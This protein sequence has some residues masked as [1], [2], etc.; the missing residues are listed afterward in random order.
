[1]SSWQP[2]TL[3]MIPG[4]D[5]ALDAVGQGAGMLSGLLDTL[6]GILKTIAQI[7]QFMA[8]VVQASI[9]ALK[10]LIQAAIYAIYDLLNSG[11]YFYLD[12][13]AP[14]Y[15]AQPDG[16]GGFLTRWEESFQ[17]EGDGSRPVYD[18]AQPVSAMLFLVGA[19]SLPDF[20]NL[21][22][23]LGTLFGAPFWMPTNPVDSPFMIP[24]AIEKSMGT[25]PDWKGTTLGEAVPPFARLGEILTKALSMIDISD[26]V[27]GVLEELARVIE[28]KASV[29]EALADEIDAIV[30]MIEAL[31]QSGLY[32]LQVDGEGITELVAKAKETPKPPLE[33]DSYV[34][35][36]CLLGATADFGPVT[37]LLGA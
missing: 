2:F 27:S 11:L 5:S 23:L 25:P 20:K 30:A 16:V 34:A 28:L 29:L 24:E 1:M 21:L 3:A 37:E 33:Q 35:G 9:A 12:Q 26:S 36:V 18:R 10:A 14:F 22:D 6:A 4:M 31:M 8:D 15:A 13:G 32:V 17:D 7:A 19:N